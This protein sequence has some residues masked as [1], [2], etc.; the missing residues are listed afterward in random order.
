MKIKNFQDTENL[1]FSRVSELRKIANEIRKQSLII[2]HRAQSGHPG[3]SLSEADILAA[4]YFYKLRVNPKNPNWEDRDRFV[5]SKGHASPGYYA[6]L[7]MKG[8]FPMKE[9]ETFRKINSRLQGH[10]ELKTPGVDFAGGSLGQGVCFANGIAIAGKLD[11]KKYK[12]YV[13]IGDGES[14]E[15]AV[16]EAAM[17]AAHHKLDNLVVILDKNQVQETGK[18]KD[19]MN[20]DPAPDKWKSFGFEAFDIDG[21]DMEKIVETL[22]KAGNVK[23]KPAII[24]ANTI[25]GKGVSFME[26]NYKFH[27]KAPDDEQFKQ[28]MEELSKICCEATK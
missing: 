17:A 1:R 9:L 12:V 24:V 15:G 14:Q 18:T 11:N 26:L 28:A 2:T 22:D 19:V 5:L 8:Y 13:L 10:P 6:A 25:K 4:L 21:H 3:G 23:G 20:I 27:G 16:W 7:A